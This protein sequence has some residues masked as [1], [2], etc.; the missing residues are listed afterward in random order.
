[1]PRVPRPGLGSITRSSSL[2]LVQPAGDGG[3]GIGFIDNAGDVNTGDDS[4]VIGSL[5][6]SV[7][8][9]YRGGEDGVGHHFSEVSRGG[10]IHPSKD[11][12]RDLLGVCSPGNVSE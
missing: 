1:M 5:A 4:S 12:S 11:H 2:L 9:V 3:G 10:L 7:V 8:E 6:L